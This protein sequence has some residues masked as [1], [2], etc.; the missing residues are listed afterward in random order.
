MT[1]HP[2]MG[3]ML[4]EPMIPFEPMMLVMKMSTG[5]FDPARLSSGRNDCVTK[6]GPSTFVARIERSSS[7]ERTLNASCLATIAGHGTVRGP[8]SRSES[9]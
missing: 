6:N 2:N 8:G 9:E 3:P 4:P 5:G 7:G 1:A